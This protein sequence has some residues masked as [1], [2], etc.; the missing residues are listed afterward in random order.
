MSPERRQAMANSIGHKIMTCEHRQLSEFNTALIIDQGGCDYT[1]VGGYQQWR[2]AGRQVRAGEHGVSIW[3][4][5]NKKKE[6]VEN[7]A[8]DADSLY[9][10]MGTIFDV[11]Q[12]DEIQVQ[13][14]PEKE[15]QI[16]CAA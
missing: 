6:T 14:E 2:R 12:T 3:I 13:E 16:P 4:P 10:V 1:I 7:A 15:N 9:F 5:C 11:S 8:A